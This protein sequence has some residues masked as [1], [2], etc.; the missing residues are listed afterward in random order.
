MSQSTNPS[1]KIAGKI[2]PFGAVSTRKMDVLEGGI[3][4]GELLDYEMYRVGVCDPPVY[5]KPVTIK[6]TRYECLLLIRA[7]E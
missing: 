6:L 1:S 3:A 2:T 4:I 7:L 5:Q